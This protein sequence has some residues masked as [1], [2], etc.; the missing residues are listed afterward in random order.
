MTPRIS[1]R[2]LA[3]AGALAAA[4]VG[5]TAWVE[6]AG[7]LP[8]DEAVRRW[9]WDHAPVSGDGLAFQQFFATLGSPYVALLVA[10][11]A[12]TVVLYNV[13]AMPALFVVAAAAGTLLEQ[14]LAELVGSTA[15]ASELDFEPGGFPSG[16]ALF[17]ATTMGAVAVLGA[18]HGRREVAMVAVCVALL[19]GFVRATDRSHM[20]NEVLG[21][22][23]LGG[24]WLCL[25]VAYRP[26]ARCG[27]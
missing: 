9:T 22:Y 18:R 12:A 11:A 7:P 16:H 6:L 21:G 3:L 15:A 26:F 24:A 4:F 13:G 23:L 8:G 5:L 19:M 10:L 17:A 2:P 14:P 1:R 20:L 27:G 25:L